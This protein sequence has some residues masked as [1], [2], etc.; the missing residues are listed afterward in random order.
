MKS[1]GIQWPHLNI[2][3]RTGWPIY[4]KYKARRVRSKKNR[5]TLA[6]GTGFVKNFE[7]NKNYLRYSYPVIERTL[8]LTLTQ[9]LFSIHD[10]SP[11]KCPPSSPPWWTR[12]QPAEARTVFRD[13]LFL[14]TIAAL[15]G[16]MSSLISSKLLHQE[17]KTSQGMTSGCGAPTCQSQLNVKSINVN[18]EPVHIIYRAH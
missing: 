16:C 10:M 8:W 1:R 13:N 5:N 17:N 14:S 11:I 6:A 4:K 15:V 18:S 3:N 9:G 7:I 12:H 2:R